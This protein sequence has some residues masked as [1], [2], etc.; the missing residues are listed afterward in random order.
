MGVIGTAFA[1]ES[2]SRYKSVFGIPERKR[3]IPLGRPRC[4]CKNN[5]KTN[6]I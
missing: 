6:L 3:P 5:I 1:E 2:L 4:I